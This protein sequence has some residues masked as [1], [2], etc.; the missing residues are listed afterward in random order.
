[1]NKL[2]WIII[3]LVIIAGVYFF[4]T[5]NNDTSNLPAINNAGEIP[6]PPQL[7]E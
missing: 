2:T 1:M 5:K 4:V 3:G 6:Q 7:P